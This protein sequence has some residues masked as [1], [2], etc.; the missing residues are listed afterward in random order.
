MTIYPPLNANIICHFCDVIY[1]YLE[2]FNFLTF[3][4]KMCQ[5]PLNM[6]IEVW[7]TKIASKLKNIQKVSENR[8][9]WHLFFNFVDFWSLCLFWAILV[10]ELNSF[11]CKK[12]IWFVESYGTPGREGG[13]HIDLNKNS[14][15]TGCVKNEMVLDPIVNCLAE[16][17]YRCFRATL[18]CKILFCYATIPCNRLWMNDFYLCT[19]VSDLN[20][21]GG[22]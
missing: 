15:P 19:Y 3:S 22:A 6:P 16:L 9:F 10:Q 8:S 1:K 11:I 12:I 21:R 20:P 17:Y 14:D 18:W 5:D 2:I 13:I 4:Q 7:C